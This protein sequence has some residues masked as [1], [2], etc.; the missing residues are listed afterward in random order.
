MQ[1]S[2]PNSD[3]LSPRKILVVCPQR[4][5][6][7]LLATPLVRS[8]KS[9]WPESTIHFLVFQGTEGA[10][11]GNPDIAEIIAVPRR[12][13]AID[14]FRELRRLWRRYD[15]AVSPLATD[16]ARIYCWAAARQ[17]IGLINPVAKDRSKAL[18][19]TRHLLFDDLDTHTVSMGLQLTRLMGIQPHFEV[20]APGVPLLQLDALLARLDALA[21]A[22]YAVLHPYPKFRY[23]M[24]TRDAWIAL[25]RQLNAR[26]MSI[27]FT[28]SA[29]PAESAYVAEIATALPAWA[30][31]LAGALSLGETA[32]LI[33][34]ARLYVGPD[35]AVTHI[36][37][38][39]GV[40][41]V[42]LFGP[43]NPV[44][45]GPWPST[46]TG[47]SSPWA[48]RGSGRQGNVF[49]VQGAGECVPCMLEGCGRHVDSTSDCLL[50]LSVGTVMDAVSAL[51][52]APDTE[53]LLPLTANAD[54]GH[55]R[56][57]RAGA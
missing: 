9:A 31:N 56:A 27:V 43:S 57:N 44:K 55:P 1:L 11:E 14:R 17:R 42:A 48:R 12:A 20:V 25:A 2:Q 29:D 54:Q 16:R 4:I 50:T 24:W 53:H 5:G 19:L 41:T 23:K 49:L 21:G 36:A 40:A 30:L 34:R 7:V 13:R 47:D 8:M 6:D 46:W 10:L 18:L 39:T 33:R 37:A 32:E 38:A 52:S 22:P 35:T 26:G 28:G 45:W 15:L 51:M 3:E